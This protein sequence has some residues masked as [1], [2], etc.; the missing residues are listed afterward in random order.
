[1]K[2]LLATIA[3]AAT[4][5]STIVAAAELELAKRTP[6]LGVTS[7]ST[8]GTNTDG[9]GLTAN[10]PVPAFEIDSHEGDRV[11][12][13]DLVQQGPLLVIFY[14]GGWCPYCNL[15]IRQ[16][17]QA[18][19]EFESREVLPVLISVDKTDGAALAQRTYE[20]PFPVLSDTTLAAHEAFDVVLDLDEETVEKYLGYGIDLNA[21]SGRSDGKIAVSSA[22]LVNIEGTVVWAHTDT[23]YRTRPSVAQL[24]EVIDTLKP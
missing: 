13:G 14:R 22:F 3:L 17:T 12:F 23:D 5:A 9:I 1:M 7:E 24:L 15:Q 19:P 11:R 10:S 4:L 18:W 20:I 2:Q 6:E 16:L 8:L 21:W